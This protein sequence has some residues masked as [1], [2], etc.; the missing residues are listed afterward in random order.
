M[1]EI[2]WEV[3]IIE[4][5]NTKTRF[6]VTRKIPILSISETK[7]F[8]EKTKALQQVNEWLNQ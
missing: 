8:L 5:S 3:S 4:L 6:K 2:E 1:P 7:V